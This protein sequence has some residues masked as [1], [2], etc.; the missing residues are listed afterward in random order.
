MCIRLVDTKLMASIQPFKVLY[1]VLIICDPVF[2]FHSSCVYGFVRQEIIHNTSLGELHKRL[3]EKPFKSPQTG[4]GAH[5]T[6]QL[7]L[8]KTHNHLTMLCVC[9]ECPDNFQSYDTSSEQLHEAGYDAYITGLC[10]ISMANYLGVCV[11]AMI[12]NVLL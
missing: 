4:T 1:I 8:S 12:N 11:C 2:A 9:V 5:N 6:L 7:W 3:I 10:F